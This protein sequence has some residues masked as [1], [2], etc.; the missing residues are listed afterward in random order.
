MHMPS[1]VLCLPQRCLLKNNDNC[2]GASKEDVQDTRWGRKKT[3]CNLSLFKDEMF[4]LFTCNI[5]SIIYTF[6]IELQMFGNQGN[7]L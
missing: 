1:R 3:R 6:E 7:L 5:L 4:N 2:Y